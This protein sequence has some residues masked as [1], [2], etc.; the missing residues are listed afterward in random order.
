MTDTV[1][2]AGVVPDEGVTVTKLNG[3][4]AVKLVA[5]VPVSI[6]VWELGVT[7]EMKLKFSDVGLALI[8]PALP[9]DTVKVMRKGTWSLEVPVRVV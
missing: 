7:P 9:A 1:N 4:E 8:V 5:L 3:D 2:V 6:I